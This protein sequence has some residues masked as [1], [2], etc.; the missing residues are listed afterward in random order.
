LGKTHRARFIFSILARE[1]GALDQISA[2][3]L[4]HHCEIIETGSES[5]RVKNGD[6]RCD[7]LSRKI[8]GLPTEGIKHGQAPLLLALLDGDPNA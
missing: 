6:A 4:T 1:A 5:W 2:L 3:T 7:T 8:G